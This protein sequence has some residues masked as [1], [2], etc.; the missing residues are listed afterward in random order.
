M[1]RHV[2]RRLSL[3]DKIYIKTPGEGEAIPFFLFF[4]NAIH[5]FS[6]REVP[7]SL[8]P[9]RHGFTAV[10]LVTQPTELYDL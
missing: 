1:S 2:G 3:P 8:I 5:H 4:F 10:P 7:L 6:R 9:S